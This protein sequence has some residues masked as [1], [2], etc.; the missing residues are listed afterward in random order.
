MIKYPGI[1][2][3]AA[4][5]FTQHDPDSVYTPK[6][7]TPGCFSFLKNLHSGKITHTVPRL[8]KP[9]IERIMYTVLL[10][11]FGQFPQNTNV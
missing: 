8:Q 10:L 11:P 9:S 3:N 1:K 5:S 2:K 6:A 7:T 4:C